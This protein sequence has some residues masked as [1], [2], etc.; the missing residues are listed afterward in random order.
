[1][2]QI[3]AKV[4]SK[5]WINVFLAFQHNWGAE[6]GI[7]AILDIRSEHEMNY[8]PWN[9]AD[10][11]DLLCN[12]GEGVS[13]LALSFCSLSFYCVAK[14]SSVTTYILKLHILH[15]VY[16]IFKKYIKAFN[17]NVVILISGFWNSIN[18]TCTL[19]LYYVLCWCKT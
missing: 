14:L 6:R 19:S 8:P 9:S 2:T 13:Q 11:V 5:N 15:L 10:Y 1:M 4:K 16:F 3:T 7:V 12:Q 17:H 18:I